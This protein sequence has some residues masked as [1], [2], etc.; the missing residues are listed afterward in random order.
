VEHL[1]TAA[2]K[3]GDEILAEFKEPLAKQVEFWQRGREYLK[4]I[5]HHNGAAYGRQILLKGKGH[6]IV[7]RHS[8][9]MKPDMKTLR[10]LRPESAGEDAVLLRKVVGNL[11]GKEAEAAFAET[12][13]NIRAACEWQ[14]FAGW[15]LGDYKHLETIR[16]REIAPAH[17]QANMIH[18]LRMVGKFQEAD[19][20]KDVLNRRFW[21]DIDDTHGYYADILQDGTPTKA[22]HAAQAL[23]LLAGDIVTRCTAP[24]ARVSYI[25]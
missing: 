7:Y 9:D 2:G 12:T 21:V 13:L 14:D 19:E 20:L 18:N 3:D 15:E 16:T 17:L 22:V 6:D 24:A 25:G 11:T 8:S 5:Q 23:V 4:G 10:G 1:A